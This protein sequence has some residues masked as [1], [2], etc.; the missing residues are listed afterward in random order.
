MK[1]KMFVLKLIGCFIVLLLAGI[2]TGRAQVSPPPDLLRQIQEEVGKLGMTVEEAQK[3]AERRGMTIEQVREQAK[4]LEIEVPERGMTIVEEAQ[5]QAR[6][7]GLELPQEEAIEDTERIGE[8]KIEPSKGPEKTELSYFGYN[9]FKEIPDAFRPSPDGPI[10]EGYLIGPRDELRLTLWGDAELQYVLPV[11]PEGR[12]FIP[13]LGQKVVA[14]KRLSTLRDELKI[15]LSQAYSGLAADPPK[16]MMD[17]TIVRIRP[18]LIYVLGELAQPGGYTV[19][20]N[21]TVFNVLYSVGGPLTSGSLRNIKVIHDI[22][23]D[24]EVTTVDMYNHL[25]KGYEAGEIH[26]SNNDRVFIPPRGKTVAIMGEVKRPAIYELL[27]K[28]GFAELLEYCGGLTAEAYVKRFQIERIIPFEE[29]D[30]P[31]IARKVLD[32]DMKEVLSGRQNVSLADGDR[33]HILSI[34][35]LLQNAVS[36]SGAVHQPGRYQISDS[37]RTVRDLILQADSLM[38]NAY[39]D[40]AE[41]VRINEDSTEQLISLNLYEVL[42]DVPTQ[43]IPLLRRDSLRIYSLQELKAKQWVRITGNVRTPGTYVLR[44]SMTVYDLLFKGG[45]LVDEEFVKE[46]YLER[47][48]LFRRTPDGKDEQVIPFHLGQALNKEGL[49]DTLLRPQDEIRIY[50]R[51]VDEMI[52]EEYVFV[53]GA[54]KNPGQFRLQEN[55]TLEDL[56]VR[57]G[58]FAEGADITKAEISRITDETKG[59]KSGQKSVSF[60]VPLKETGNFPISFALDDTLRLSHQARMFSLKHRDRVYI[61]TDPDYQPQQIVQVR[62]EV[63]YPG[64]YVLRYDN[65]MLSDIIERAGGIRPTAYPKGGRLFRQDE[66]LITR[67]DLAIEG[68]ERA[69]VVLSPGDEIIIPP[70]PNTVTVRGNVANE[71]LVKYERGRHVSYYLKQVGGVDERVKDIYLTQAN[72]ASYSLKRW[73]LLPDRNPTVDDGAIVMVTQKAPREKVEFDLGKTLI[74]ATAVIATSLWV[75]HLLNQLM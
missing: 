14:G 61:R 10:D 45:G 44:D 62:G 53:S 34:L 17:L 60:I 70:V 51:Y 42:A 18:I 33:V 58:G 1:S 30:D 71:G 47:A 16:V 21:S 46:T 25:L 41:L 59:T 24:Y 64:E 29:R 39:W 8:K 13:K 15:W 50:S 27:D 5:K 57:A 23:E 43:N 48:D 36:I 52:M 73:S 4:E 54:V 55:M 11:D 12:I 2:Q 72:G 49:A 19:S 63:Y 9:L 26:L 69:D 31:S 38:G 67:I 68:I 3:E 40:K 32:V 56:I 37:V 75:M 35:S 65:E 22:G 66:Q 28:E 20:S 7:L 6:E 74:N